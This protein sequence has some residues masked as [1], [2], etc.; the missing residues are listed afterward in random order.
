V[1]ILPFFAIPFYLVALFAIIPLAIARPIAPITTVG[2]IL[3]A[4]IA[5]VIVYVLPRHQPRANRLIKLVLVAIVVPSATIPFLQMNICACMNVPMINDTRLANIAINCSASEHFIAEDNGLEL[6]DTYGG[7]FHVVR[8]GAKTRVWSDGPDLKDDEGKV[9]VVESLISFEHAWQ[10]VYGST[11]LEKGQA[12]I[13]KLA[14]Y[15]LVGIWG[16]FKG[17]IVWNVRADETLTAVE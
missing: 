17:D 15:E 16:Q 3:L 11:L 10:T 2:F 9:S 8:S 6:K 12:A 7:Q 14:I 5:L 13:R 4:V 1:T